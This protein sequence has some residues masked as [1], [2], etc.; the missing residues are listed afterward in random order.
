M[1][2]R[3]SECCLGTVKRCS[4]TPWSPDIRIPFGTK[5]IV[6]LPNDFANRMVCA[7]PDDFFHWGATTQA[8]S[9]A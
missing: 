5:L 3:K 6:G 9:A 4:D 2:L 1:R 7:V 8:E